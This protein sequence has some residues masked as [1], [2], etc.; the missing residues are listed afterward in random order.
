MSREQSPI[1]PV[2]ILRNLPGIA[3]VERIA[4]QP[5]AGWRENDPERVALIDRV[6]V[7]LFGIT[8]GDTERAPP[9]YGDFLTEGDRLALKHLAPIDTGDR[10]RYAEAPYDRAVAEHVAWEANFDILYDDTDLDDDERDEFWRILGVDVTDGSGEDLHCLHNFSRQ[11]IVLAK[12]LLPGAV[13]KPD[14]SGTRAP[15][16]AQAWGAALERAAHEF[17]ARKR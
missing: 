17:K 10:F 5:G 6:S 14:G 11:L 16:D 3:E 15:P 1:S 8:E 4:S 7:S 12:G 2:I 13:F 9:D